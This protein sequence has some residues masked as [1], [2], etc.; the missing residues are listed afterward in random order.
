MTGR[1]I[2]DLDDT[3][4]GA[5]LMVVK[6][7]SMLAGQDVPVAPWPVE[8]APD[9]NDA[10]EPGRW[11]RA[12]VPAQVTPIAPRTPA[13]RC[14]TCSQPASS[15]SARSIDSTCPRMRRTR[16]RSF[17]FSRM[18]WLMTANTIGVY[19]M[20]EELMIIKSMQLK[21]C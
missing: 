13:I 4:P 6:L 9:Q 11:A 1:T 15:S 2:A 3:G 14:I 16:A 8:S 18:V 7:S 17:C 21:S 20:Q 5:R 12:S 10:T 19:P